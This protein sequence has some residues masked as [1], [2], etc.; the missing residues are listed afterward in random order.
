M[1]NKKIFFVRTMG[2]KKTNNKIEILK[3]YRAILREKAKRLKQ[4]HLWRRPSQKIDK[5]KKAIDNKR[6]C[7]EKVDYND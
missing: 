4:F 7:R 3:R 1:V 2:R 5:N 6:K